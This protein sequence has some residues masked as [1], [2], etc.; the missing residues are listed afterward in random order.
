MSGADKVL[1]LIP[2]KG[3]SVRFKRKNLARIGGRTMLEWAVREALASGVCGRVVVS[4]ED[5][6][7][8]E[9]AREYG[10]ETPFERPAHLARDPYGIADVCLHAL[11]WFAT[12]GEAFDVLVILQVSSPL[13]RASDIRGA[14]ERF[15]E[16]GVP[17]LTTIMASE[18]SPYLAHSLD[19]DTGMLTPCFPDMISLRGPEMPSTYRSNGAVF[20]CRV[21]AFRRV[22]GFYGYPM[23]AYPMS[24]HR[25][26]DV[27]LQEDLEYADFLL[28]HRPELFMA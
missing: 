10:A 3:A 11:D 24:R 14:F 21:E 27:D 26:V 7:V 25:S 2:A 28:Q 4:T 13:R 18:H 23:A 20:I 5:R 6:E 22:R 1:T 8:A 9:R 15:R 12:R 19:H 17:F 16:A